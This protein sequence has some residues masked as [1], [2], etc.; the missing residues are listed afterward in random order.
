MSLIWM[1]HVLPGV[2]FARNVIE[3][4]QEQIEIHERVESLIWMS[5]V[6]HMNES[7]PLHVC[8]MSLIWISHVS[9]T[10]ESRLSYKRVMSLISMGS[11]VCTSHVSHMI[12]SCLSYE[13]VMSLIWMSHVSHMNESCL[14]RRRVR[15]QRHRGRARA[16]RDIWMSHVSFVNKSCLSR[17][18]VMSLLWM[19]H[20]SHMSESCLTRRRVRAQRHPG[21]ATARSLLVAAATQR[22]RS[23]CRIPDVYIWMR[24]V[25]CVNESCCTCTWVMPS[26]GSSNSTS[27]IHMSHT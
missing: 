25:S 13:W 14:T 3:G 19:S 4:V 9:H 11:L 26:R 1:R 15:A 6:S 17:E 7:C 10:N 23:R 20:V 16:D 27:A 24:H 18:W 21:H 22:V 2:V 12:E 8:V 5:H